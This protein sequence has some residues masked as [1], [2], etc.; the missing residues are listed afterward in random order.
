MSPDDVRALYAREKIT[1]DDAKPGAQDRVIVWKL[2]PDRT[3]VP[4]QLAIGLT[5][6][7]FT[8]VK[9]VV[10]GSLKPGDQV[11]TGALLAKSQAPTAQQAAKK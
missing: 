8:E 7:A 3:I 10:A 9:S 6:H 5:D 2:E 11:V 4:V 1:A